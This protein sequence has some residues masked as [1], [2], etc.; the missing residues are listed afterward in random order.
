[1]EKNKK[2]SDFK[3]LTIIDIAKFAGV[4]KT[5][6]S[7]VLANSNLVNKNTKRKVLKI[8]DKYNFKPNTIARSLKTSRT[9]TIG[10]VVA[11]IDNPYYSRISK[12]IIDTAELYNY[13][14]LICNCDFDPVKEEKNIEILIDKKVD[15]LI[16]TTIKTSKRTIKSLINRNI[17]FII[18][19]YKLDMPGVAY[20]VSDDYYGGKIVTEYL[21]S[22][23]H[24]KI[25]FLGN[26]DLYS[27]RERKK[28]VIDTLKKN[29]FNTKNVVPIK[30][31][32]KE[33][34]I[35]EVV[36][37]IIKGK[38]YTAIFAASDRLA[39][40]VIKIINDMGFNVP[41]DI[42][43]VGFDDIEFAKMMKVAL[44]TV[45]QPK[46]L[47]G[48]MAVERLIGMIDNNAGI[49]QSVLKPKLVVRESC[50]RII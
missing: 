29:G 3:N 26:I 32:I 12:G 43:V 40:K 1:M 2:N 4:S 33:S 11:D 13:T 44:T 42:S 19:D 5:T 28:G 31:I 30:K 17:S 8:I 49:L 23:G 10:V 15:G 38:K 18:I 20:I 36:T 25:F 22:L 46:Y 45:K 39:I 16:I 48:K 41:E 21:I 37:N 9:R 6:I 50:S 47:L 7:R 27:F 35:N 34:D 14:V 24:K